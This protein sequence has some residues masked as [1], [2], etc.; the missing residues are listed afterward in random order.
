MVPFAT[1]V[2][3]MCKRCEH[4]ARRMSCIRCQAVVTA[5]CS[6]CG[7]WTCVSCTRQAYFWQPKTDQSFG[8]WRVQCQDCRNRKHGDA[9]ANRWCTRQVRTPD[10]V[11]DLPC[12]RRA[13]CN[14]C[15][16]DLARTKRT[17]CPL[18]RAGGKRCGGCR[19]GRLGEDGEI[20]DSCL[21]PLCE[22]CW[23]EAGSPAWALRSR[24][25]K[26]LEGPFVLC[27]T[28]VAGIPAEERGKMQVP[29]RLGRHLRE[30][31][32]GDSRRAE[33]SDVPWRVKRSPTREP[34]IP[35][36]EK[37]RRGAGSS[38]EQDHQAIRL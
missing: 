7:E 38:V 11:C 9:C 18:C 17:V 23:N 19:I 6:D 3:Y 5:L 21:K 25:G 22:R 35:G 24:D 28:C 33:A 13:V 27:F 26:I 32:L 31:P 2:G 4:E 37:R 12:C 8:R 14:E 15:K 16:V 36:K 20:C 30:I 10:G 1:T 34:E 29:R